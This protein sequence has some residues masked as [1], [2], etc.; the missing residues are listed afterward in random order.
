MNHRNFHRGVLAATVAGVF[1][2]GIPAIQAAEAEFNIGV[3]TDYIDDGASK[4]DNDPVVQGGFE[5]GFDNGVFTGVQA[6]TLGSGRG[7]EIVPFVGYGFDVGSVGIEFGY[8]HFHYTELDER[9]EGETFV[10]VDWGPVY[11]GVNYLAHAHDRDARGSREFFAGTAFE[12]APRTELFAEVGQ[13]R[14]ADDD[15]AVFWELGAAHATDFGTFSLTYG[16]RDESGAQDLLVGGYTY[17]F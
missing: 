14:P 17:N 5:L 2:F 4:S 16:S 13:D 11:T 9:Y 8:E 12:V 6:S 3:F 1:A 7:S 10:V 15:N